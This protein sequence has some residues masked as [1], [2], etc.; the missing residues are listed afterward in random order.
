MT[1]S[2]FVTFPG[3]YRMIHRGSDGDRVALWAPS[4]GMGGAGAT[5]LRD[6]PTENYV[7]I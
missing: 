5:A 4:G 7:K 3:R 1:E 6:M 2:H